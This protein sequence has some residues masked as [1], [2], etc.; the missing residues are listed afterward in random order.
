LLEGKGVNCRRVSVFEL[1]L[2]LHALDD[3]QRPRFDLN[4]SPGMSY[5]ARQYVAL[6]MA[7]QSVMTEARR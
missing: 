7:E 5:G 1:L 2:S 6:S 4:G 3:L